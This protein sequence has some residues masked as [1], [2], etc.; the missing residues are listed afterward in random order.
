M[1]HS[2]V[3]LVTKGR[4]SLQFSTLGGR[5]GRIY[6]LYSAENSELLAILRGGSSND[7]L[8]Y[9]TA[10]TSAIGT[11]YL[12]RPNSK[13]LGLFGS[14]YQARSHLE[15]LNHVLD[16]QEVRVSVQPASIGTSLL[17]ACNSSSRSKS[18][19]STTPNRQSK[20]SM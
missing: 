11:K 7:I 1:A 10:A 6:I 3:P 17:Q 4:K 9:R 14:G 8:D 20:G 12:A 16:L 13:V 19:P 2:E 15:A 18:G 5:G